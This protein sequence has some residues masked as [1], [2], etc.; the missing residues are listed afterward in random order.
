[1]PFL[2]NKPN[3]VKSD[4]TKINSNNSAIIDNSVPLIKK[5]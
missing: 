1:M 5:K 2:R 4:N 3:T